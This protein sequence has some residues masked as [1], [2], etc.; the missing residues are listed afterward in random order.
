MPQGHQST[1]LSNMAMK[2]EMP[3]ESVLQ[4]MMSRRS[5]YPVN[6]NAQMPAAMQQMSQI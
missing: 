1:N 6:T 5:Q 2:Q 4:S 3:K